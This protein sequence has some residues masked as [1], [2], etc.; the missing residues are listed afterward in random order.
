MNCFITIL[1]LCDGLCIDCNADNPKKCLLCNVTAIKEVCKKE[2][3]H[4][5]SEKNIMKE[6]R[7]D[8]RKRKA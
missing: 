2:V 8:G 4:E 5:F 3:N 6:V 1:D 7:K